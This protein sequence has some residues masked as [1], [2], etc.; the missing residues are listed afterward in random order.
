MAKQHSVSDFGAQW[1]ELTRSIL[2]AQLESA[3]N[4]R[5]HTN[6]LPG[7][8]QEETRLAQ[9]LVDDSIRFERTSVALLE[10]ALALQSS[11]APYL[12]SLARAARSGIDAREAIWQN[13]FRLA[14]NLPAPASGAEKASFVGPAEMMEAWRDMFD[15]VYRAEWPGSAKR[16]SSART[17]G[18]PASTP[19]GR[20]ASAG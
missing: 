16:E 12:K 4:F 17:K 11:M 15:A 18:G 9:K 10:D 3:E 7:F 6:D 20:A 14:E 13:W 8:I 1:M 5:R 2:S 19:G